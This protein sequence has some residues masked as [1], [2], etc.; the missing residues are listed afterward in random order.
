[1]RNLVR[2]VLVYV[3]RE[4]KAI[5]LRLYRGE[6]SNTSVASDENGFMYIVTGDGY[7]QSAFFL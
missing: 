1:M 6:I 4:L 5:R 2:A 3:Y 7:A